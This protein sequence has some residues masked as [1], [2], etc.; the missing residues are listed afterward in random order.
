MEQWS[1]SRTNEYAMRKGALFEA[2]HGVV[3]DDNSNGS[4]HS[5]ALD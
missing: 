4:R 3:V 1:K 5:G 2:A